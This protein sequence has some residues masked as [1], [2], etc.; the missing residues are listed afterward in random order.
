MLALAFV[1]QCAPLFHQEPLDVKILNCTTRLK[2]ARR[3][4][5][6]QISGRHVYCQRLVELAK[7]KA[8]DGLMPHKNYAKFVVRCHAK[9]WQAL[10]FREKMHY[11]AE[12]QVMR[13]AP[14]ACSGRTAWPRISSPILSTLPSSCSVEVFFFISSTT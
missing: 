14:F 4:Q 12:P 10:G 11:H 9:R 6:Q 7:N 1:R 13:S 2:K 8:R 3:H 5:P